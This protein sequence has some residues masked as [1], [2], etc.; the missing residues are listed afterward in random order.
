MQ[1][2]DKILSS[3]GCGSRKELRAAIRAGRV[4]VNGELRQDLGCKVD[5]AAD[6]VRVDGRVVSLF[7]GCAHLM[8]TTAGNADRA[9]VFGILRR[10]SQGGLRLGLNPP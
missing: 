5:P 1:R 3:A 8:L 6:E 4:T 10:I 7:D 2:L 9:G